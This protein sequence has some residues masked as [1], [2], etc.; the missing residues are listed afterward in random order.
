M[1]LTEKGSLEYL[2]LYLGMLIPSEYILKWAYLGDGDLFPDKI[3]Y[4]PAAPK[5][6]TFEIGS[7]SDLVLEKTAKH[8]LMPS[9][10]TIKH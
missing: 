1:K 8:F 2:S 6:L 5:D 3:F 4:E 10:F 7:N 9:N